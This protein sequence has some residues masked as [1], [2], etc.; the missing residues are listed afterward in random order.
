M[1][2]IANEG[3]WELSRRTSLLAPEAH[4]DARTIFLP[5]NIT[6]TTIPVEDEGGE[7][8]PTDGYAFDEYRIN[9]AVGLPDEAAAA[10]LAA[11]GEESAALKIVTGGALA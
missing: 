5:I 1:H 3:N 7:I 10:L 9:R 4:V 8:I 11:F 6:K 2:L